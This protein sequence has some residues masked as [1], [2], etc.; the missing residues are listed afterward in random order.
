[1][2]RRSNRLQ[3][4]AGGSVAA[5][6]RGSTAKKNGAAKASAKKPPPKATKKV[7]KAS[8]K[9]PSLLEKAIISSQATETPVPIK[10]TQTQVPSIQVSLGIIDLMFHEID[11]I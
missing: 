1:M 3:E 10:S 5:G 11:S 2:A 4:K 8:T 6:T 7:T 9:R